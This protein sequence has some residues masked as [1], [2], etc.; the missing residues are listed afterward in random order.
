MRLQVTKIEE[1]EYCLIPMGG[2]LPKHPQ[3][4]LALGGTA[5]EGSLCAMLGVWWHQRGR[6]GVCVR[7]ARGGDAWYGWWA[8]RGHG[9]R[10]LGGRGVGGQWGEGVR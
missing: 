6:G 5:G 7:R 9:R 10:R 4:V 3:R 2:V 1:E 8:A